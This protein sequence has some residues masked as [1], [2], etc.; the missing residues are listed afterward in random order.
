MPLSLQKDIFLLHQH[1]S[2][3]CSFPNAAES[4]KRTCCVWGSKVWG[5]SFC[6]AA[7]QRAVCWD[8]NIN[9]SFS[10]ACRR[11]RFPLHPLTCVRG[12]S[13][14]VQTKGQ[15]R[16][17]PLPAPLK[18]QMFLFRTKK[19][20]ASRIMSLLYIAQGISKTDRAKTNLRVQVVYLKDNV[21]LVDITKIISL[22]EL[23]LFMVP[24]VIQERKGFKNCM[25]LSTCSYISWIK[26][27]RVSTAQLV[28]NYCLKVLRTK[29]SFQA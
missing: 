16:I 8:Y 27:S 13:S 26:H 11:T 22:S 15:N 23:M 12:H 28:W 29:H 18:I 25:I 4:R 1:M 24:N 20:G 17:I 5:P 19:G 21:V 7:T 2:Q 14:C 6:L 3:M 9:S 10:L